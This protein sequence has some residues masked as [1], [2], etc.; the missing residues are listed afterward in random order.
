MKKYDKINQEILKAL[1]NPS[2]G[3]Q[4]LTLYLMVVIWGLLLLSPTIVLVAGKL[5][6]FIEQINTT[7]SDSTN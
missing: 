1:P 6:Q 7:T 5:E 4:T 3:R 2:T